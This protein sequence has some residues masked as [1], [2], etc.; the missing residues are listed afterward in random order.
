MT[1]YEILQRAIELGQWDWY[2]AALKIDADESKARTSYFMQMGAYYR[3]LRDYM[4][5]H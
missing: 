5:K 4:E 2:T 3:H 1:K